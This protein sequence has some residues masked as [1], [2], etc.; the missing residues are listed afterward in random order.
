M[1]RHASNHTRTGQSARV[2]AIGGISAGP[3]SPGPETRGVLAACLWPSSRRSAPT[4]TLGRVG[5]RSAPSIRK[6]TGPLGSR[7]GK[8][9]PHRVGLPDPI[10]LGR[11]ELQVEVA[12]DLPQRQPAGAVLPNHADSGLLDAVLHELVVQIVEAEGQG[13]NPAARVLTPWDAEPVQGFQHP[14]PAGASYARDLPGGQM[15][16]RVESFERA[17]ASQAEPRRQRDNAFNQRRDCRTRVCFG[18]IRGSEDRVERVCYRTQVRALRGATLFPYGLTSI[19]VYGLT[20]SLFE[21]SE[22][23]TS[24]ERRV[25]FC[26]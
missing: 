19:S 23:S 13:A 18:L 16:A 25:A 20:G 22:I 5:T 1:I 10:L 6:K 9:P 4:R 7:T 14:R 15:L 11:N 24:T 3:A 2:L 26:H 17:L 8:D 12:G 21:L